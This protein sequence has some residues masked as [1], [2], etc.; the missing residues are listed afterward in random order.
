MGAADVNSCQITTTGDLVKLL[1]AYRPDAPVVV[2]PDCF[3]DWT[4]K[5]YEKNGVLYIQPYLVIKEN[6]PWPQLG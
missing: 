4:L 2:Q 3:N 5:V 6:P 1:S